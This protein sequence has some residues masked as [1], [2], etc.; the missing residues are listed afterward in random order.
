LPRLIGW[1]KSNPDRCR[2]L[3]P[4]NGWGSYAS[5]LP[6]LQEMAD[7]GAAALDGHWRVYS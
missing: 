2:E 7:A 1:M 6:V 4:A 3:N 5:L